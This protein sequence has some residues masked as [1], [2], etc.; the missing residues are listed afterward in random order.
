VSLEGEL[1]YVWRRFG[2]ICVV[3]HWLLVVGGG[4]L[5]LERSFARVRTV[6]PWRNCN[7]DTIGGMNVFGVSGVGRRGP[8][9]I[10]L[11]W[12]IG[13]GRVVGELFG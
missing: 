6:F 3:V 11:D 13:E 12:V 1:G 5:V 10:Q 7:A 8:G 4:W 9:R 2:E